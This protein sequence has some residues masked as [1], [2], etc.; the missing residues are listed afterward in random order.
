MRIIFLIFLCI[1]YPR[2][3][4]GQENDTA[5]DTLAKEFISASALTVDHFGNIFVADAGANEIIKFGSDG[6]TLNK[7][8]GF[9]WSNT[10]L[11]RPHDIISPN[12]L[13]IYIA[14]FGNHRI[15][16]LDRKLNFIA[17]IPAEV[18]TDKQYRLFGYPLS[19]SLS[20]FGK[21]YILDGENV[22]LL[23]VSSSGKVERSIGGNEAGLGK[24]KNPQKVR[25]NGNNFIFVKDLNK[26]IAF[27]VFGNYLRTFGKGVFIDLKTFSIY[28]EYLF[29]IDSTMLLKLDINGKRLIEVNLDK[30]I[31]KHSSIV[32]I[33][34]TSKR[35]YLLTEHRLIS[36][37]RDDIL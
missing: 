13:D 12:S 24:L 23:K 25:I 8:G 37:K 6:S 11:D 35:I 21:L 17:S 26:I 3:V 16:R 4:S 10:S 1:C 30:W 36:F 18:S 27:D 14:D 9:G 2:F 31:D 33:F 32:D 29:V 28:E 5:I 22:Q 7:F 15:L 34:V 19:V 20:S